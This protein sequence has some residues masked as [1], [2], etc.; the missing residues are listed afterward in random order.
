MWLL[1]DRVKIF[2]CPANTGGDNDHC[3]KFYESFFYNLDCDS[4]TFQ[5]CN[6]EFWSV[7][8][9]DIRFIIQTIVI[10]NFDMYAIV[11][12]VLMIRAVIVNNIIVIY[13]KLA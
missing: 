2:D 6:L 3:F 5:N 4:M 9:P 7:C 13:L 11:N 1:L 12:N 10:C 8:N